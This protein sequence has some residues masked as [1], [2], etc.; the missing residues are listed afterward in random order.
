MT[1]LIG[2]RTLLSATALVG[3]LAAIPVAAQTGAVVAG[4][5]DGTQQVD[6]DPA[7]PG[8]DIIVTAR[9]GNTAQK[10]VEASY[11]ISTISA[12]ELR[13]KAPVGVGEALKNVPGFWVESSSGETSGNIRVRGIPTDGYS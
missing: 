8:E 5:A 12:E 6:T 13:M 7:S 11:A 3:I 9:A 2:N 1:I 10:K 4:S